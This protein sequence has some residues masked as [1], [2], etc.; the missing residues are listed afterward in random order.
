[1]ESDDQ[2]GDV[3]GLL[4][5]A[6][7]YVL[8]FFAAAALYVLSFGPVLSMTSDVID[9]SSFRITRPAKHPEWRRWTRVVYRPLYGVMGG[10]IG[11]SPARVLQWY[12]LLWG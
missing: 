8:G 10:A 12:V 3:R 1:M 6:S 4:G 7:P 2:R 11:Y 9:G 5:R